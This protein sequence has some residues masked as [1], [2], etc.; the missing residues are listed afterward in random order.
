MERKRQIM[1]DDRI[2]WM[3]DMSQAEA[4][5]ETFNQLSQAGGKAAQMTDSFGENLRKRLQNPESQKMTAGVNTG[6][7]ASVDAMRGRLRNDEQRNALDRMLYGPGAMSTQIPLN[8]P[9]QSP[10]QSPMQWVF[11]DGTSNKTKGGGDTGPK[12]VEVL[13]RV[14]SLLERN[15]V[16]LQ[17]A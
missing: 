2:P 9:Q 8:V 10:A 13:E 1:E 6:V 5:K 17:I 4:L 14:A 3:G 15:L 16:S 7:S 11:P 12:Q